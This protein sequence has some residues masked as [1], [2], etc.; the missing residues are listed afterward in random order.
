MYLS[1]LHRTAFAVML[2]MAAS[3]VPA[4]AVPSRHISIVE[5]TSS[6][7]AAAPIWGVAGGYRSEWLPT[8]KASGMSFALVEL[9]WQDA[10]PGMDVFDASYLASI[11]A[12]ASALRNAGFSLMLN[13][14]M[15][16]APSWLLDQPGARFVDQSGH[17]H[18]STNEP[19]LVFA[20]GYRAYFNRYAAR[21][22][23]TLGTNFVT[24]RV[25]GGHWGELTF[26]R[27][28]GPDGK[29]VNSYWAFDRFAAASS[30]VPGWRPGQ[31]SPN[32][33][34]RKFLNWYLTSLT[35]FQNWQVKA[36]RA[37]YPGRI[38]VLYPSWGMRSGD[39][40][41]AVATN[42]SGTSRP[43]INGEVQ[44]GI[45]HARQV[46]ALSDPSTAVWCTW[47]DERTVD[48]SNP[49]PIGEL[50][51]LAA[52]KGLPLMGENTG[53]QV[54]AAAMARLRDNARDYRMTHVLWI[55]A[56]TLMSGSSAAG[57]VDLASAS[58]VTR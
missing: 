51:A 46:A 7:N 38:A 19:N 43:E 47:A 53:G 58:S 11:N 50:S 40:D 14:G 39:F 37:V 32:G 21:V 10:E 3:F 41:R 31:L 4:R 33:E 22:L 1:P 25:G 28:Y 54:D 30:P 17:V 8:L 29:V 35:N 45:D 48:Q 18:T 20:T 27:E 57:P 23:A 44:S 12:Q 5:A 9:R 52:A 34:A 26:P 42:L 55:R 15:D 2:T 56:A 16:Y 24:V 36:I 6:A 49:A 13:L